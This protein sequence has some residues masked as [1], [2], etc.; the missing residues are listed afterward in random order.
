M[1]HITVCYLGIDE[2]TW[3]KDWNI[4]K[5]LAQF[6]WT[7]SDGQTTVKVFPH[8]TTGDITESSPAAKP[9]FQ[10]T[11]SPDGGLPFSSDLSELAGIDITLVQPPLPSGPNASYGELPGTSEW[12]ATVPGQTSD[13]TTLGSF[14]LYQPDGGD[15]SGNVTGTIRT[16]A[17]GDE[18][19]E[20]FW[21]GMPRQNVGLKMERATIT[22]GEPEKWL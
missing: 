20:N 15:T 22:F 17:V 12:A 1:I 4:P 13:F 6:E 7:E 16:N 14:D 18:Y 5:H 9:W 10:T 11:F 21:P 19:F 8:D 2:L 3:W